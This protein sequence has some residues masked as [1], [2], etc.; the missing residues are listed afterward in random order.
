MDLARW[1]L[2]GI[3]GADGEEQQQEQQ[4]QQENQQASATPESGDAQVEKL[5]EEYKKQEEA[6]WA[7]A[8]KGN[9]NELKV[10]ILKVHGLIREMN[11]NPRSLSTSQVA[12][13]NSTDIQPPSKRAKKGPHQEWSIE[14]L[15]ELKEEVEAMEEA[16]NNILEGGVSGREAERRPSPRNKS[17]P[18]NYYQPV[19]VDSQPDSQESN[20][21][22]AC[23]LF[24]AETTAK[25][26]LDILR[27][28]RN[29][30]IDKFELNYTQWVVNRILGAA[31]PAIQAIAKKNK[32]W[33]SKFPILQ[34]KMDI[35]LYAE[36]TDKRSQMNRYGNLVSFEHKSNISDATKREDAIL[37]LKRDFIKKLNSVDILSPAVGPMMWTL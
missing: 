3:G 27:D 31:L 4:D 36:T 26:A 17:A 14:V 22:A 37:E 18:Q 20:A 7:L 30:G 25:E 11:P 2:S 32:K 28:N 33:L 21:S 1:A 13:N 10:D 35:R 24:N 29:D 15:P 12:T 5:V 8:N 16:W 23:D 19:L 34:D 6:I 9:T